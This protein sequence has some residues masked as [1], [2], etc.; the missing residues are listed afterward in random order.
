M[1]P[2][3]ALVCEMLELVSNQ[4]RADLIPRYYAE[5]FVDHDLPP[6]VPAGRAA[7]EGL[8]SVM[9]HAFPDRHITVDVVFSSGDLVCARQ[10]VRATHTGEF[11]GNP[12]TGRS[13]TISAID[14]VRLRDGLIVERW[15]NADVIGLMGQLGIDASALAGPTVPA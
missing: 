1:T 14:I 6:G 2:E 11:F 9:S 5:D 12:P 13:F 4:Q 3:E 15:G 7:V 8:I 10:T